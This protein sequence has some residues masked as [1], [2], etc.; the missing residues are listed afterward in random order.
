MASSP[1]SSEG[2]VVVTPDTPTNSMSD[3]SV[4]L[5]HQLVVQFLD[6]LADVWEE[7]PHIK[8]TKLEYTMACVQSPLADSAKIK[9]IAAYYASMQPFF[10]QCTAKD[11]S[12]FHDPA[13]AANTFLAKIKFTEKWTPDL[14]PDTKAHVWQ[15]LAGLNQYAN[16]YN[17]YIKVPPNMLQ[18]I[19]GMATGIASKIES[20]DMDM[21]D[22]N[23][24]NLGQEVAQNID[25]SELNEFAASMMQNKNGMSQLYSMLGTM[26][27]QM[28]SQ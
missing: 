10:Q 22:L 13:L 15:Y 24:Q 27:A 9:L 26:M 19:E 23:I 2:A 7:C 1:P 5:F 11:D 20:G 14:H 28:P 6:A 12:I 25:M 18:T 21:K 4:G 3:Q 16:M 17:L 8:Q